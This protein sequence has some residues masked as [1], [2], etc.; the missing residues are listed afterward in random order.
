VT[1]STS[2][3]YDALVAL[4]RWFR[5]VE[6][7]YSLNAPVRAGFDGTGLEAVQEFLDV[8]S[9]YCVHFASAFAIMAR[10]LDMPARIVVGYLPGTATTDSIDEQ[11]VHE[12]Y[13][14]QL[15]AWPE[16]HFEGIGWIPFEP[17]NSLG[18][19]TAFASSTTPGTADGSTE[20]TA[21]LAP[22]A[23]SASLG[24]DQTDALD[25]SDSAAGTTTVG[26]G[27]PVGFVLAVIA[28]FALP[29]VWR[30]IRRRHRLI[31]AHTGDAAAA[32][33]EASDT[34]LDLGIALPRGES[35]RVLGRRLVDEAGADAAAMAVLVAAIEHASYAPPASAGQRRSDEPLDAAVRTV[36]AGLVAASERRA[37]FAATLVPRSLFGRRAAEMRAAG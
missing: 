25:E 32:W 7:E 20:E 13:S 24:P 4:Q 6:F 8:K 16:V 27:P 23:P 5:G 21:P 28:V 37:R 30:A 35:P 31:A 33:A 1:S 15:H 22:E 18:V 2:S 36:R 19:P 26:A 11:T 3:D 34:A 14:S 10:T 9:G 17:T 12:V 29:G